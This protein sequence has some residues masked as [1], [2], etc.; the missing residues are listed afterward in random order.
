MPAWLHFEPALPGQ[1]LAALAALCVLAL[2]PALWRKARGGFWRA[3]GFALL[4]LV[5]AG[6]R[7]VREQRQPLPDIA[8]LVVDQTASMQI[9]DRT[10]IADQARAAI[11]TQAGTLPNLQLRTITV[12]DTGHDGTRLFAAIDHALADIP[13]TRLAGIVAI[14]DGQIADIPAAPPPAP[15]HILLP[16]AGPQHDRVLRLLDAPAYG[17]VGGSVT[18]RFVVDDL[19]GAPGTAARVTLRHDGDPAQIVPVIGGTPASVTIPVTHPGPSVVDL[20]VDPWPGEVSLLN[21]RAVVGINGVRDRLRV[22]LVSGQPHEGERTWRRLLKADPAVD[23]VHFTI[24]RLPEND[25][26]TPMNELALIPF[27]VRELFQVKIRD[28][29]LI[30]LDR[31]QS[32]GLLPQAYLGNIADYVR[33]GGGLLLS[34]GPEFAGPDSLANT[35][36]G[37]VLPAGPAGGATPERE[38]DGTP[39]EAASPA[40]IDQAFRPGITP[41]GTRHPVTADLPGWRPDAPPSWGG[42]YR[43]ILPGDAHGQ[44][45]MSGPDGSPL[46]LLDRVGKGRVALLLSDQIWLWSRGHQG[47]GPQAELLRRLAHWLMGEPELEEEALVARIEAGQLIVTRH[48]LTDH[49]AEPVRI[50]DPAGQSGT[51]GLQAVMP[52]LARAS[53]PASM[54]GMWQ[55]SDGTR[56]AYAAASET[57]SM[58]FADLRVSPDRIAPLATASGGG[59]H[60]LLPG[61]APAL[62]R[63]GADATASGAGW[64]GLRRNGDGVITGI[65]SVPLLP[66]LLALPIALAVLLTAWWWEGR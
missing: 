12:P 43:R 42:W 32:L 14:T 61:G 26:L 36:I 19:G 50:T 33:Q 30:V 18:L 62:R 38:Q 4:I 3:A 24:L 25:D 20:Q 28:F 16:A 6:P 1:V 46:L 55:V 13:R 34:V 56:T 47:G 60:W 5:L 35:A 64:I 2:I 39:A 7:M 10:R 65:D 8:L 57:D 15:L 23:L 45:L 66:P 22:L 59:V 21:N 52:G 27:P 54:P 40:V 11:E 49:P 48:S 44:A 41:I 9:G 58:E 17:L 53:M 29:D 37:A 63:V 31:F 51:L